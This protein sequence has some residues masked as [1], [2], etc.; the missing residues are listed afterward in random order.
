MQKSPRKKKTKHNTTKALDASIT[1][2]SG[3]PLAMYHLGLAVY[4]DNVLILGF[5]PPHKTKL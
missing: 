1:K 3:M 2:I 5:Y 4:F